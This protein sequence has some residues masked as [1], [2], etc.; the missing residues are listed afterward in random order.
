[1]SNTYSSLGMVLSTG[2]WHVSAIAGVAAALSAIGSNDV[3]SSTRIS[4]FLGMWLVTMSG[5]VWNDLYD[6]EMDRQ[7]GKM[8]PIATGK[9]SP[10]IATSATAFSCV[11]ALVVSISALGTSATLVLIGTMVALLLYSPFG[12]VHP[13]VKPIWVGALCMSPFAFSSVSMG[14]NPDPTI[15]F[16]GFSFILTRELLIDLQDAESDCSW[17]VRTIDQLFDAKTLELLCWS[18]LILIPVVGTLIV[19]G[20]GSSA[21]LAASASVS[22]IAFKFYLTEPS[23]GLLW[24]RLSMLFA[25]VAISIG[26]T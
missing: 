25:V 6:A 4:L 15:L 24:T 17:G 11:L 16:L 21:L 26:L 7:A 10:R 14:L 13:L 9:L 22:A 20:I 12:R 3:S 19:S 8:R 2:R 1:M 18:A 5:F 23:R